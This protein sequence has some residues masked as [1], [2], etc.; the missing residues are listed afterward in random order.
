VTVRIGA[1]VTEDRG[2]AGP[3]LGCSDGGELKGKVRRKKE[4]WG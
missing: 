1:G 4:E 2:G 3:R